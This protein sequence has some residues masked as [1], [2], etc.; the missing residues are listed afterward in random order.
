M[1]AAPATALPRALRAVAV[2]AFDLVSGLGCIAYAKPRS[3]EAAKA[4]DRRDLRAVRA[5][6]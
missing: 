2:A 3:R 4:G 6:G 1:T 5:S